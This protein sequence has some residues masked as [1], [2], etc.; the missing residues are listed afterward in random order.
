M[1]ELVKYAVEINIEFPVFLP[2]TPVPGTYLYE[3]VKKEDVLEI[4]DF[5]R[6]DWATPLLRSYTGF[7]RNDFAKLNME[8]GKRYILYRPHWLLRGMFSRPKYRNVFYW[9][10]FI[11]TLKIL[12]SSFLD[13]LLSRKTPKEATTLR[14][15]N[16]PKWYDS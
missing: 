8:L 7:S 3:E 4:R 9:T 12:W 1:L 11:N 16:K 15:V 14:R 13:R 5:K 6:Y 2:I 10:Y